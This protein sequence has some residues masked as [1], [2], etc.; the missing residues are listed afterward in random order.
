ML[1]RVEDAV[2]AGLLLLMI[3]MA[4]TQIFLRNFFEGGIVWGDVLLRI[5][6]LWIGLAGAMIASRDGRH[7]NIDV[8][9]RYLPEGIRIIVMCAAELFTAGICSLVGYYS[10]RFVQAEFEFGG[11]AFAQIPVWLCQIIIPF[12]FIVI[13]IRYF[14][15]AVSRLYEIKSSRKDAKGA[16]KDSLLRSE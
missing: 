4:A 9:T 11:K 10:I 5:L 2:L 8:M 3:G 13:A 1:R 14:I 7:I 16:K 15:L 12:A 6:V